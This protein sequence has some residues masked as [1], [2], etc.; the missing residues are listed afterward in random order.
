MR[1]IEKFRYFILGMVATL[2]FSV[3]VVPAF[4][5]G[6]YRQLD[7]Y[8]NDVKIVIDGNQITPKDAAGKVVEPFIVDGTTYLP[9]RAV[10]EA[11]G[12]NVTWDGATSTVYIGQVPGASAQLGKD[13][14]AYQSDGRYYEY[15]QEGSFLMAGNK[16]YNGVRFQGLSK[17]FY[18]LNGQYSQISGKF[19]PT[20]DSGTDITGT[21]TFWGDDKLLKTIDW[22]GSDMPKSFNVDIS[23]VLQLRIEVTVD[24]FDSWVGQIA[25]VDTELT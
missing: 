2:I 17:A 25:L 9:V 23:G 24:Y 3:T 5:A 15:P 13:I 7:A 8:Y 4:A 21:I 11:F 19:G 22:N 16:Y 6:I 10:G 20:D 18:N 1:R 14:T 12:K